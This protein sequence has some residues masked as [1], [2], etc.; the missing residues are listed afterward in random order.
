LVIVISGFGRLQ[1]VQVKMSGVAGWADIEKSLQVLALVSVGL[2]YIKTCPY[3][4]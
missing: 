4:Q 1:V 2:F 3:F